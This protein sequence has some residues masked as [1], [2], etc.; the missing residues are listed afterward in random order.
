M[1]A[2]SHTRFRG[3]P[4]IMVHGTNRPYGVGRQVSHGCFRLFGQDIEPLYREV[5]VGTPVTVVDQPIKIGWRD[6][7]L[8]LEIHPTE[9]QADELE[10]TGRFTPAPIPDLRDNAPRMADNRSDRI[11]WNAAERAARERSGV[12]VRITR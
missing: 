7:A 3:W 11:D 10:R 2:D 1:G 6:N 4:A 8:Y 9:S 5:P 12:P